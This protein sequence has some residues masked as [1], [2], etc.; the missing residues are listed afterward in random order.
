MTKYD[1][2]YEPPAPIAEIALRNSETGERIKN[3]FALLDTGADI[4]LLP[5]LAVKSLKI[6]SLPE[7]IKL[8]GFDNKVDLFKIYEL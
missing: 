1:T 3:I 8:L 7:T 5:S 2:S 6:N 4:S